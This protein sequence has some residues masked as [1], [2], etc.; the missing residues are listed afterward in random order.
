MI[1]NNQ[2]FDNELN[3]EYSRG[4]EINAISGSAPPPVM[5][6]GDVLEDDKIK[7]EGS[8]IH[9]GSNKPRINANTNIVSTPLDNLYLTP[10]PGSNITMTPQS[11]YGG[12]P[13]SRNALRRN[14]DQM[15][16]TVDKYGDI[17][18]FPHMSHGYNRTQDMSE[19]MDMHTSKE[20][21]KSSKSKFPHLTEK[22]VKD[23]LAQLE[24]QPDRLRDIQSGEPT[25][26]NFRQ[27][28]SCVRPIV[29][30]KS[31]TPFYAQCSTAKLGYCT[32]CKNLRRGNQK[33]GSVCMSCGERLTAKYHR[34][35][36]ELVR[37]EPLQ[38]TRNKDMYRKYKPLLEQFNITWHDEKGLDFVVNHYMLLKIWVSDEKFD[39]RS[40][41]LERTY[42]VGVF[43]GR[44]FNT[45]ALAR[46]LLRE[47]CKLEMFRADFPEYFE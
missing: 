11:D 21:N 27:V 33:Q 38:K 9:N 36:P 7:S 43:A 14:D 47:G 34:W 31:N 32:W 40:M 18:E 35:Y 15:N 5:G 24:L 1:R 26:K 23:V 29:C 10:G 39:I 12:V 2:G 20:N 13:T 45:G 28:W 3:D 46:K 16:I 17:I 19:D 25:T 42:M 37:L 22:E 8:A 41:H 44:E 30:H 6:T 4:D